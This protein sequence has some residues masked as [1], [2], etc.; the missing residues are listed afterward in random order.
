M[1]SNRYLL[2]HKLIF[3]RISKGGW[4]LYDPEI[5]RHPDIESRL[6]H[7][8]FKNEKNIGQTFHQHILSHF[9]H[10]KLKQA[11]KNGTRILWKL[12]QP[13]ENMLKIMLPKSQVKTNRHFFTLSFLNTITIT[14]S[15]GHNEN[16]H[17]FN[18]IITH[19]SMT[20]FTVYPTFSV[21]YKGLKRMFVAEQPPST[22]KSI[23]RAGKKASSSSGSSCKLLCGRAQWPCSNHTCST[24]LGAW[25]VQ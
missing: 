14:N 21:V 15:S 24:L 20:F 3:L 16:W 17:Y 2:F 4:K 23:L 18:F 7:L 11:E 25:F 9:L 19:N 8:T 6:D 12:A 22:V 5:H 1:Q 10:F 13:L